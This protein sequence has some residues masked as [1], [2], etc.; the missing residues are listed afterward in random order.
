MG[1]NQ[2]NESEVH[3]KHVWQEVLAI[4]YSKAASCYINF[5]FSKEQA[6]FYSC[7]GLRP[8]QVPEVTI[9]KLNYTV[10]QGVKFSSL[11]FS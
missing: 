8:P 4:Y 10:V 6:D 7:A 11:N 3:S 1:T 2:Y 5:S 9:S